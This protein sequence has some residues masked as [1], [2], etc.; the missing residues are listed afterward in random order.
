MS[1]ETVHFK[2]RYLAMREKDGWE[3][4]SRTNAS[5]VVVLVAVTP[6]NEVVLVEQYRIPVGRRTIELP[7]G[8]VGDGADPGEDLRLA[9]ARELEEETGYRAGALEEIL[10]CPSSAGM[11]DEMITFFLA[12]GLERV[13]PGGGVVV[14]IDGWVLGFGHAIFPVNTAV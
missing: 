5:G 3:Y 4:T 1:S 13:G 10:Y 14:E 2:G 12:T 7:A 8:L 11:A 9:A 6:Q